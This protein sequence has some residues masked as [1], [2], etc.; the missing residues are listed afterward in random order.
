LESLEIRN[1]PSHFGITA[2][3]AALVHPVHAAAQ[4]RHVADSE[5]N[6]KKELTE[7]SL[8][9]DSS[10]DSNNSPGDIGSSSKDPSSV[11]PN[12]DR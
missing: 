4:V 1:A 6:H 9:I 10:R 12:S 7:A 3:M 8:S 5:V 11:D 2:H